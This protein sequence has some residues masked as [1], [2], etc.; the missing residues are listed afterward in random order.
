[1]NKQASFLLL[2]VLPIVA[3]VKSFA[4]LDWKIS[5][6]YLLIISLITYAAYWHDKRRAR[7]N[8]WRIPENTLHLLELLGGWPAAF[9]AQQILRHKTSKQSYRTLYW[10]IVAA[11]QFAAID[12]LLNWRI[13]GSILGK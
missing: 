2:I 5:L 6:G 12:Y 4:S 13:T 9:L 11:Y 7:A 1:M 8:G 3:L 10:L